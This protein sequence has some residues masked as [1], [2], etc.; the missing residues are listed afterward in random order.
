MALFLEYGDDFQLNQH[1]GIQFS[2]G[3]TSVRQTITRAF[4]TNPATDNVGQGP[5]PPDY[6]FHPDY[7]TGA[8]RDIGENVTSAQLAT[9]VA[10]LQQ[11][12]AQNP[13]VNPSLPATVSVSQNG[14][15]EVAITATV[16][17]INSNPGNMLFVVQ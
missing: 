3:W 5:L 17:L 13:S 1:G 11:A 10:K 14:F 8:Q 7:G 16:Y 2:C 6:I 15:Q 12:A 9:V 4:L